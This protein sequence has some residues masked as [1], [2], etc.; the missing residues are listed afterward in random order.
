MCLAFTDTHYHILHSFS[1]LLL[2]VIDIL[3]KME[4]DVFNNS[5]AKSGECD[6]LWQRMWPAV[7]LVDNVLVGYLSS[8]LC[9]GGPGSIPVADKLDSGFHL[10]G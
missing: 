1:L 8:L 6:K 9:A 3:L 10:S 4:R 7:F 2:V 5:V